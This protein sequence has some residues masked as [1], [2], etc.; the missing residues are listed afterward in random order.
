MKEKLTVEE[1]MANA[2]AQT[3]AT[4]EKA[5]PLL[6]KSALGTAVIHL[7]KEGK[8]PTKEEMIRLFEA[9]LALKR[10]GKSLDMAGPVFGY[11]LK[12]LRGEA[13]LEANWSATE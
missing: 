12:F 8:E 9:R 1:M 6:A 7:I 13:P 11:A 3:Q 2:K 5:A 10:D 4:I